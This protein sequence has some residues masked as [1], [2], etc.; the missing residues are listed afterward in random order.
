MLG[1]FYM[2][3]RREDGSHYKVNSL[4]TIRL[5]I[6]RY[7]KSPPFNRKVDIV[8]DS[9]F[10]DSNTCFKTVLAEAKRMGKVDVVHHPIISDTDLKSLYTSMHLSINTP[11]GLFNKVQFDIRMF[12]CRRGNENMHNMTKNMFRVETDEDTG[13]KVVKKVVDELTK[14]I[15]WTKKLLRE[16]CQKLKVCFAFNCVYILKELSQRKFYH[17]CKL[18]INIY[19]YLLFFLVGSIYC[20]VLSFEMYLS[21]LH[22]ECDR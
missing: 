2:D 20:P 1:H 7:L 4:E 18:S 16:L 8:K 6:N 22:P 19:M 12:F 21:K 3:L 15:V 11:Q 10:T 13:Q 5:G 9:S 17:T 14:D